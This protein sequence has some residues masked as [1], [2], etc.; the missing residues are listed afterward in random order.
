MTLEIF[1]EPV[2]LA[3]AAA[4]RILAVIQAKPDALICLAAGETPRLTYN[5]LVEM[6]LTYQVDYSRLRFLTLDEWVGIPASNPGS[7]FYFLNETLFLPLGIA[8][9][10]IYFFHSEAADLSAEC[11]RMDEIIRQNQ[12]LDLIL[13]GVGMNGH[14]GF[15]EPGVDPDLG[16][17]V[18]KLDTL[19]T[20]IGQKYFASPTELNFGITLGITHFMQAQM[21]IVLAEGERKAR[22]M[23]KALKTPVSNEIPAGFIRNH[24]NGFVMI[25]RESAVYL[26]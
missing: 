25:D 10:H 14:I 12:G 11:R 6:L 15:N 2:L 13:V 8:R 19:T 18:V 4:A 23:E 1:E 20:K 3:R 7:C 5:V 22:I 16:S 9:E 17:H 26:A 24:Q 21:A